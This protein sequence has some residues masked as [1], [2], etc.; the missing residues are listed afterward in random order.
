MDSVFF[1]SYL[2]CAAFLGGRGVCLYRF[3]LGLGLG[4]IFSFAD[5]PIG[6]QCKVVT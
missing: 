3:L 2:P 5:K 6:T 1:L 4:M